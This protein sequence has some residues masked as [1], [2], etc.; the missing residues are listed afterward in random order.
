MHT[1][2]VQGVSETCADRCC[3]RR[4]FRSEGKIYLIRFFGVFLEI[5]IHIKGKFFFQKPK[6]GHNLDFSIMDQEFSPFFVEPVDGAEYE[7]V[8]GD[9]P[10]LAP[11]RD[12]AG[13]RP[14]N[15]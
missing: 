12:I 2:L 5:L 6:A 15:N 9:G 11:H 3:Q 4:R 7:L 1:Q 8:V 14:C 10:V 13:V